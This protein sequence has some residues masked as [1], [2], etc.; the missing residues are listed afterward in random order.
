MT[1]AEQAILAVL[2]IFFANNPTFEEIESIL[3]AILTA[4]GNAK[5]GQAFQVTG[6]MSLKGKA[7]TFTLAWTPGTGA[8]NVAPG[9]QRPP[10]PTP[11]R[12]P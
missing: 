1:P 4:V 5:N 11:P 6:P 10:T 12:S 9:G 3:P 8:P 7:G 2:Q